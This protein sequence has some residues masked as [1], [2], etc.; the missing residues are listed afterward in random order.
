MSRKIL[1]SANFV[2]GA[3]T[4]YVSAIRSKA[5]RGPIA[6]Q[7]DDRPGGHFPTIPVAIA[8]TSAR[9]GVEGY[10]IEG[11]WYLAMDAPVCTIKSARTWLSDRSDGPITCFVLI[12]RAT[13]LVALGWDPEVT[14]NA[15]HEELRTRGF[16]AD[17]DVERPGS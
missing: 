10:V 15:L 4:L 3:R 7:L 12:C 13:D 1:A 16:I 11:D 5:K 6:I 2:R 14:A 9:L 8:A 17:G